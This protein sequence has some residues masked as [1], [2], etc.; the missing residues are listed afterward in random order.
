MDINRDVEPLINFSNDMVVDDD[1]IL[2]IN[3][4][5]AVQNVNAN[6]EIVSAR[7][8]D[9]ISADALLILYNFF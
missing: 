9:S 5:E 3:Q 7:T 8:Q 2:P 4:T 6:E 1:P